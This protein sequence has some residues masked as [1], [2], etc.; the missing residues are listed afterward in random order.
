M[1][2]MFDKSD[3]GSAFAIVNVRSKFEADKLVQRETTIN[4]IYS[5]LKRNFMSVVRIMAIVI[6][7][8]RKL[9][10]TTISKMDKE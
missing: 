5:L 4:Y 8:V 2:D 6:L 3:D 10:K 7:A 9:K 1:F